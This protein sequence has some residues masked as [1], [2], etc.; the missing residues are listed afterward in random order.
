[1]LTT[2]ILCVCTDSMFWTMHELDSV[3]WHLDGEK[4]AV[5]SLE[6]KLQADE[7]IQINNGPNC[8][9]TVAD[10]SWCNTL[11]QC[12]LT[13]SKLCLNNQ[14]QQ[15]LQK[16]TTSAH[17]SFMADGSNSK[18]D[19]S[20]HKQHRFVETAANTCIDSNTSHGATRHTHSLDQPANDAQAY[21][22]TATSYN[23]MFSNVLHLDV[24]RVMAT[25]LQHG[26]DPTTTSFLICLWQP[27]MIDLPM[28]HH[29]ST[30]TSLAHQNPMQQKHGEKWQ[31]VHISKDCS[32]GSV[33]SKILQ[34]LDNKCNQSY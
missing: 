4:P 15:H 19:S 34:S 9:N 6:L 13:V 14:H 33:T 8:T 3:W 23:S 32:H 24:W 30:T 16:P 12:W 27:T 28:N 11:R 20:Q 2:S 17:T 26:S 18:V 10:T 1:M 7:L 25:E 22:H 29:D 31:T 5:I 21:W